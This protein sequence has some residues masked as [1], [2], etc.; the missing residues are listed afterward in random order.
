MLCQFRAEHLYLS[1]CLQYLKIVIIRAIISLT[2][3]DILLK[4]AQFP[5]N[6]P[7]KGSL[8]DTI[9]TL[10]VD[11]QR[12]KGA[13]MLHDQSQ[14]GHSIF[15]DFYLAEL[16]LR[17]DVSRIAEEDGFPVRVLLCVLALDELF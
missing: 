2:P 5:L 14:L 13:E 4:L 16:M 11:L 1:L 17:E 12:K 15:C 3:V 8:L 9:N 7:L 10:R 6:L